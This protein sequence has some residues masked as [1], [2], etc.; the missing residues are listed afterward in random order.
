MMALDRSISGPG[1]DGGAC[2]GAHCQS[3]NK[4]VEQNQWKWKKSA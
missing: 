3:L 1:I 2:L 4:D